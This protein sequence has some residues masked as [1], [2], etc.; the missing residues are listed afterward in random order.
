[1]TYAEKLDAALRELA[2]CK[3]IDLRLK[4][5]LTGEQP[6]SEPP[7]PIASSGE[8]FKGDEQ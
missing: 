3:P 7:P 5:A 8:L 4:H 6:K 1:M 2:E